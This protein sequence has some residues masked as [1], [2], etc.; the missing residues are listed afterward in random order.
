MPRPPIALKNRRLAALLAWL[1]PGLGHFYQG[2]RGKGVL[3]FVCILGL[4]LMGMALGG[5][6]VVFWRW[7]SPLASPEDFRWWYLAQFWAGLI[8]LPGLI[9]ATLVRYGH[10]PILGG[11]LA[12]PALNVI[13]GMHNRFGRYVDIGIVYTVI[14]GLLNIL[15][16]Y[17][18]YDG[19][20]L[21][22]EPEPATTQAGFDPSAASSMTLEPGT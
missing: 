10:D 20:A 5:T 15:A 7:L 4:F 6:K 22:D 8:A 1:V 3:Y 21:D 12:E 2:R 11:Y 16:I 17:D 19:P 13:N 14:A 9:Q 18:A